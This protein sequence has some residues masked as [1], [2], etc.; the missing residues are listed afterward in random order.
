MREALIAGQRFLLGRLHYAQF[1]QQCRRATVAA[2]KE[3]TPDAAVDDKWNRAKPFNQI[4]G[5]KPLPIIGTA[6]AFFPVIGHG[7]EVERMME[8]FRMQLKKYG[9]IW[10]EIAPGMPPIVCTTRPEDAQE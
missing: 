10:K 2:V 6:W 9:P 5:H 1:Q 3:T 7:I 4:P 8:V